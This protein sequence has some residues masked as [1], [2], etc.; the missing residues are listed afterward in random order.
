LINNKIIHFV[1]TEIEQ[2][3][4]ENNIP[5][6]VIKELDEVFLDEKAIEL[7]R[8]D[9]ID[10]QKARRVSSIAFKTS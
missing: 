2:Y 1:S 10:H 4:I 8:E 7:I 5:C 9:E 6:G 3:T